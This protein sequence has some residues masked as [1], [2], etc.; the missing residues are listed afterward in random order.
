MVN[1]TIDTSRSARVIIVVLSSI[2]PVETCYGYYKR[3]YVHRFRDVL[4]FL[5]LL[6]DISKTFWSLVEARPLK[7]VPPSLLY[8]GL[9]IHI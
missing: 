1:L 4:L 5:S 7:L 9:C 2:R 8:I 3:D 6:V